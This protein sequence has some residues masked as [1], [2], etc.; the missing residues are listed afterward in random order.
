M[1]IALTGSNLA[2]GHT[3]IRACI[4]AYTHSPLFVR[5]S[6]S[7]PPKRNWR[8]GFCGGW[9]KSSTLHADTE[10]TPQ[11]D[12]NSEVYGP[13]PPERSAKWS[14]PC[15]DVAGNKGICSIGLVFLYSVPATSKFTWV[16]VRIMVP[17]WIPIFLYGT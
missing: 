16:V 17:F 8:S 3:C 4:H 13:A 14:I 2:S 1:W 7:V 11:L 15:W 6:C 12:L 10:P 5:V 9:L